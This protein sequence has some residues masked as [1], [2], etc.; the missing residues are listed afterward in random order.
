MFTDLD[1]AVTGAFG[2][3]VTWRRH[4]GAESAVTAVVD[5]L[6]IREMGEGGAAGTANEVWTL[7]L[8]ALSLPGYNRLNDRFVVR[9]REA[10]A[11]AQPFTDAAGM[12]VIT[13]EV[14]S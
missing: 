9:G 8:P 2:E 3:P 4:D 7:S 10:K 11:A 1:D 12:M 5:I 13:L 14:I 6:D